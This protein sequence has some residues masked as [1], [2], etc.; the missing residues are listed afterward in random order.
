METLSTHYAFTEET[1]DLLGRLRARQATVAVVGMGYV[2]LP[3]AMPLGEQGFRVTGFDIDPAEGRRARMPAQPISKHI[4]DD[5]HRG[6]RRAASRRPTISTGSPNATSIIICV[7][8]PLTPHREPD[9]S[10]TSRTPRARSRRICARASSSCWN[11]RPIPARRDEV[12]RPILESAASKSGATSS[13]PISPE[14]EDPGNADFRTRA[15]PKVVG[16]DGAECARAW[17]RR[18]YGQLVDRGRAG[19][20]RR[21][22]GGRARCTENIFRAV[23]IALVNELKV[24]YDAMG[25]DVWEVIEAAKTKPFGFMPFYPG[26]GLGGHCIP[27]DPFYLTWKAR[28]SSACAPRFIELAGEINAAMPDYVV[29]RCAEALDRRRWGR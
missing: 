18:F 2:G 24:V 1:H 6:A 17:H 4:A 10:L 8:T 23:N 9:L 5:A 3:L 14:R 29:E 27:I 21:G 22:G 26:P 13:S 12:L 11:P 16:G 15:I 28:A 20:L 25:I 7:P 19:V